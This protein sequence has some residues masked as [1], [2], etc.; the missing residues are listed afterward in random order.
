MVPS[1]LRVAYEVL[2]LTNKFRVQNGVAPLSLS[3]DLVEAAQFHAEDMALSDYFAHTSPSGKSTFGG[4][5]S[6]LRNRLE[7]TQY[8]GSSTAENIAAGQFSSASAVN[9]WINS[10]SH[11]QNILNPR[12]TELGVGYYYLNGDQGKVNH[13]HYWAQT[14]GTGD[15]NSAVGELALETDL[16]APTALNP[17]KP[18]E[19]F[20]GNGGNDALYGTTSSDTISGRAGDDALYGRPGDDALF[21]N[22]GNDRISA[23]RG[24][25]QLFGGI[26]DDQLYGKWGNDILFGEDGHDILS[27]DE[28][29]DQLFGGTGN[30]QLYARTGNDLLRGEDGH[31][32]LGGG[33]GNDQLFGG[34]GNDDLHGRFDHDSLV[35]GTGDDILIGGSGNDMLMGVDSNIG[36]GRGERDVLIG[37]TGNDLL[38]LGDQVGVFY[39]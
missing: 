11:R 29:D 24:D 34:A 15:R 5:K 10:A 6:T 3:T 39:N 16:S 27:A 13:S 4:E 28:G 38:V 35:G 30:D 12:F 2:A 25:D 8:S 37:E 31:D 26:G 22:A 19:F 23:G 17:I 20:T 18:V 9:G 14:F 7:A 21:G 33:Y 32:H 36:R 1:R